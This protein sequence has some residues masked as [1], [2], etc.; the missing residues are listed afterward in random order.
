MSAGLVVLADRV[1]TMDPARP[2]ARAIAVTAG[3]VTALG[4]LADVRPLIGPATRV[5]DEPGL[6]V[7]PGL[8]DAHQHPVLGLGQQR[9]VDLSSAR[10]LDEL[11]ALLRAESRRIESDEWLIGYGVDY[12]LFVGDRPHRGLVDQATGAR[13]AWLWFA[14]LHTALVNTEALRR[15]GISGPVE[16]ADR[17]AVVVDEHGQPTGELREM[18]AISLV[19]RAVPSPGPLETARRL[20]DLFREQNRAGLTGAHVLDLWPGT[21]ELLTLLESQGRLT[22]RLRVAPWVRAEDVAG[23]IDEAAELHDRRLGLESLWRAGAVK[24]FLDGTIDGG[25]AWLSRPDLHGA[26]TRAQWLDPHHYAAAVHKAVGSGLSCWTHAIGDAAVGHALDAYA[27]AGRP[28]SGRH[29]I[30][31][32]EV[33]DDAD[34]SRFA[35]LD[36][37][38]SMQPT[39]MDWSQPDH[40][41]NWSTLLGPDRCAKA[42][43][44]SDLVEAG[45]H[46]AFGSDWPIAGFDPRVVMAGARLRRPV[47]QAGRR[48]YGPGQALTPAQALA[49]YT[50]GPAYAAGE[51]AVS[52]CIAVGCRA[53]LTVFGADPLVTAA[54]VLP[55]VPVRATIVG[56]HLVHMAPA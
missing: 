24:L 43:R 35:Q 26:S 40:S 29:R 47:H 18:S 11:D 20:E 16:F 36:V 15:A 13:P 10:D 19:Y 37:V 45:A 12:E 2:S 38:A 27:Q 31:H 17:S 46:V 48:P 33:L 53:D 5:L 32:V 51:E 42:W 14:D 7:T 9:G 39:H 54:D 8:V 56:G 25:S 28:I 1:H 22:M 52:G 3:R 23:S 30:E 44:Y 41:D 34:V 55:D 49:A 50:R 4:G 6:V 21:A